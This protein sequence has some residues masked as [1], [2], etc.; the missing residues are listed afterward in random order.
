VPADEG[1]STKPA[2]MPVSDNKLIK[3]PKEG[4]DDSKVQEEINLIREFHM[5][6]IVA[7][8]SDFNTELQTTQKQ[9]D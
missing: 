7:L 2:P 5:K 1:L 3:A 8:K 6:Q 9:V 4:R